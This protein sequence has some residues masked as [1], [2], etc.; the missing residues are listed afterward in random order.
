M[1]AQQTD[2]APPASS[3]AANAATLAT[4]PG[5]L[6]ARCWRFHPEPRPPPPPLLEAVQNPDQ[7]VWFTSGG[8]ACPLIRV[9]VC[10]F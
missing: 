9:P 3:T 4:A 8:G 5:Q 7:S 10:F 6:P 1:D 2:S